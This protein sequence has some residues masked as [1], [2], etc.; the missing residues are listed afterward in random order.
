MRQI[1]YVIDQTSRQH[2][3]EIPEDGLKVK[4][5]NEEHSITKENP[6]I[7]LFHSAIQNNIPFV[8]YGNK[9]VT[10]YNPTMVTGIQYSLD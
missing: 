10:L 4:I 6:Q 7:E 9:N 8:I 3:Y 5:G 2:G 1:L